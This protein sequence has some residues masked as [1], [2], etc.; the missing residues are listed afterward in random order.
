MAQVILVVPFDTE[1][2]LQRTMRHDPRPPRYRV[3]GP[4]DGFMDDN[5]ADQGGI[6]GGVGTP[7]TEPSRLRGMPTEA[8]SAFHG[9]I[10]VQPKR[11]YRPLHACFEC[12]LAVHTVACIQPEACIQVTFTGRKKCKRSLIF[13]GDFMPKKRLPAVALQRIFRTIL[14]PYYPL[15]LLAICYSKIHM[16]PWPDDC[17]NI[18]I[19]PT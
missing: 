16:L 12:R 5:L 19:A 1:T 3:L 11:L 7:E 4:R 15:L 2:N 14:L 13:V 9:A 18:V 8:Y 10:L 6:P 17:C